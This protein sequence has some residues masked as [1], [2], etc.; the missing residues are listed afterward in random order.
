MVNDLGVA[1]DEMAW[2]PW[3][4]SQS[5]HPPW[6]MPAWRCGSLR[7]WEPT[8]PH[9]SSRQDGPALQCWCP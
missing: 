6:R 8:A 5:W 9:L 4:S 1:V 7:R 3:L 2:S